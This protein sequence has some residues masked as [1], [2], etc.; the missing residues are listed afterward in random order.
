MAPCVFS[1][2]CYLADLGMAQGLHLKGDTHEIFVDII[3]HLSLMNI[4]FIYWLLTSIYTDLL[5]IW[6]RFGGFFSSSDKQLT[7][8]PFQHLTSVYLL[9]FS[10]SMDLHL[11]L[12]SL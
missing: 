12:Y 10:L 7:S 2:S 5:I 4:H 9:S 8:S 1:E 6:C 11:I 3:K